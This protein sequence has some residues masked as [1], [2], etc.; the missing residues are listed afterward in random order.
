ME[1]ISKANINLADN[2]CVL[3]DYLYIASLDSM[4]KIHINSKKIIKQFNF[5]YTKLYQFNNDIFG[6][7]KNCIYKINDKD[8]KNGNEKELILENNFIIQCFY[9]IKEKLIIDCAD[10]QIKFH[11]LSK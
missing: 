7:N 4:F 2:S 5:G 11:E 10:N 1:I 3:N 6:I 8:N 9:K